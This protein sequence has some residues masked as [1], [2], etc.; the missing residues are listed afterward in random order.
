MNGAG[1]GCTVGS[2]AGMGK[3]S[4]EGMMSEKPV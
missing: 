3:E 4:S 1:D 2:A